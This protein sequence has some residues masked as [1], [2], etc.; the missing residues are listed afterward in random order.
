MIDTIGS[1]FVVTWK[2]I[3]R[4]KRINPLVMDI[5]NPVMDIHELLIFISNLWISIMEIIIRISIRNIHCW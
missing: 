4:Q 1:Q 5:H 3:Q 2:F